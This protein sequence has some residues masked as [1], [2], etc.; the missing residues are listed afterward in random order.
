MNILYKL[1]KSVFI[2]ACITL[3]LTSMN[4]AQVANYTFTQTVDTYTPIT[5]GTVLW[6]GTFDDEF[7]GAITI[8]AFNFDGT[9]RTSLYVSANGYITFG[10]TSLGYT[11]IS[12][13][14]A[15]PGVISPFGRDLNYGASGVPEVRYEQIAN[16]FVVQWQDV[17][18]YNVTG[19]L[20][21]FQVRLNSSNNS[22]KIVYGGTITPGSN[23]TYPQVG[24]R[25][26]NNTFAT[27]VNNR[28]IAISGGNWINSLPGTVNTSTMY[29]NSADLTTVP[30]SGL[31]YTF[32]PP[33]FPPS[34]TYTAL[35]NTSSTSNRTLDGVIITDL[36]GVNGTAGT[37]PRIYFKKSSDANVFG[38][39]TSSDNGWKW[40]ETTGTSPFNFTIDYSIINGGTVS[41]SD[42]IQYFV[43]AQD[44]AT[45]PLVGANPSTGFVGTS[46]SAITSAPTTPNSYIITDLPMSGVYTVGLNAFKSITGKNVYFEKRT[47]TVMK[48][49][50][51]LDSQIDL[52]I[53]DDKSSSQVID[54][55][56]KLVEVTQEY[57]QLMEN[58][59]PFDQSFFSN[60]EALGV[61]PTLTAAVADVNL[62]GIS[63]PVTLS[64]VDSDYPNETYPIEFLEVAG[65]SVTN[66]ITIKPAAGVQTKIPGNLTQTTATLRVGFGSYVVIDGS[67]TVGGTTKDMTIIGLA[68]G[69][70]PSVHLYGYANN[71]VFE[72]CTIK[73][74]DTVAVRPGV[75]V[76]FFSSNTGSGNQLK[77]LNVYNFADYGFRLQG[78]PTTNTLVT[79]C[80]IY[81]MAPTTKTTVYGVSIGRVDG[82]ILEK[83]KIYDLASTGTA[84]I[85]GIY[86]AG[87]SAS[88]S[89]IIRNNFVSLS[90]GLNLNVGTLRGIDYF[91]Y[92]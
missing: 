15:S 83:N 73:N 65:A 26:P 39:N 40:T 2:A 51:G 43:V 16:E 56:P 3:I 81:M 85:A 64:L 47:R 27:N 11:P 75:G 24:L 92:A 71:N 20:L 91:G 68:T 30:S 72:N 79:G 31:T 35:L 61:Y 53:N 8:P 7:S 78:A 82:L 41:I 87:A 90:G 49:L 10:S 34:I 59:K 76:Y 14:T 77:N 18:R 52:N 84:T 21:S 88:G 60:N 69:T 36:D 17:R 45:I 22:I 54:N 12:S 13:T 42:T 29:F 80:D 1:I 62:R 5:G 74:I 32:T 33:N 48:D 28:T 6:S 70:I 46:V 50:N 23:T 57:Y 37:A 38:G 58:G 66:T 44:V 9:D 89:A 19:E 86:Y 63:G 67:N 4:F 25:G 55:S